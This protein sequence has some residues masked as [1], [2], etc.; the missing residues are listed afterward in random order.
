MYVPKA[1]VDRMMA[2]KKAGILLKPEEEKKKPE[3][4]F[5]IFLKRKPERRDRRRR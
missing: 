5:S 1:E 3:V 2:D 4:R